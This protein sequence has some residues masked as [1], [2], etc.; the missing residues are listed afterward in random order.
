[1][2]LFLPKCEHL[3]IID[4]AVHAEHLVYIHGLFIWDICMFFSFSSC[5]LPSWFEKSDGKTN[6]N[7]PPTASPYRR[8]Q[9]VWRSSDGEC[10][11]TFL[12]SCTSLCIVSA[13]HFNFPKCIELFHLIIYINK[14]KIMLVNALLH[15]N[16]L[17]WQ[18]YGWH[19]T[20][21]WRQL[22]KHHNILDWTWNWPI[23]FDDWN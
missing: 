4:G 1:M 2:F 10:S 8:Y 11:L 21:L 13:L 5:N 9:R 23:I 14:F 22:Q 20:L 15:F 12:P 6:C 18:F 17:I 16:L 7:T 19:I 3:S